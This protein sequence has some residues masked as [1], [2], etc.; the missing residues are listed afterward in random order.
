MHELSVVASLYEIMEKK[1]KEQKA[2]TITRVK[3]QVGVLSGV[4]PE[5]L[6]TA[7]DI[8]KKDTLA[9]EAALE[10]E[11]IPVKI[12]CKSCRTESTS[13]EPAFICGRC[14]SHDIEIIDGTELILE[15]LE[16]GV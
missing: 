11:I 1:A 8:Y 3:L 4:V 14:G 7:F 5:F 15:R 10:M 9:S 2:K 16:L 12:K 6:E 13:N